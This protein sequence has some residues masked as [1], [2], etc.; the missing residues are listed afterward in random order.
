MLFCQILLFW[1]HLLTFL[2]LNVT[3]KLILLR[4]L[5]KIFKNHYKVIFPSKTSN[6]LFFSIKIFQNSGLY[7][8]LYILVCRIKHIK[9]T[10]IG[11]STLR[12]FLIRKSDLF[13]DISTQ[14][15][16]VLGIVKLMMTRYISTD[17]SKVSPFV[18]ERVSSPNQIFLQTISSYLRKVCKIW[19]HIGDLLI[20]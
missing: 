3:G 15:C 13:Q 14:R 11:F 18:F 8:N 1:N 4:L 16:I 7:L 17:F 2:T 20:C 5:L 12:A 19:I 6:I 9:M 10:V